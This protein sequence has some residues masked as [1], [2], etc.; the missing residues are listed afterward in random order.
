MRAIAKGRVQGV[1]F[2][3]Y[4]QEQAEQLGLCG[5]VRNC[6]DGS[7]EAVAEGEPETLAE[8]EKR[9][10]H[11]SPW[12]R[13]DGLTRKDSASTGEFDGFAIRHG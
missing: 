13:V 2:R 1:C 9:L 11:G 5:W 3:L 7:V 12:S 8:F 6:P 4:V 10:R